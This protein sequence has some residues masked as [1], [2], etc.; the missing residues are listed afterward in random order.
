MLKILLPLLFFL[1]LTHSNACT[2]YHNLDNNYKLIG[3]A[4]MEYL[5]WDVYDASLYSKD[6][7]YSPDKPFILALKY[8]TDLDGA[9]IAKRSIEEIKELGFNDKEKLQKWHDLMVRIFPDIV[10]H[11][12]I[13]GYYDPIRGAKFEY[14]PL[15]CDKYKSGA[16]NLGIIAD[17]EFS[18]WFFDIWLSPKTSEPKIRKRLLGL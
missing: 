14:I 4:R 5:F 9:D 16:E 10:K 11:E 13:I 12:Q 3:K 17:T 15:E 18:K 7:N 6:G 1:S 8:L 2:T